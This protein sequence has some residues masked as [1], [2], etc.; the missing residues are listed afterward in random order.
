M[1]EK[2]KVIRRQKKWKTKSGYAY[3]RKAK[4]TRDKRPKGKKSIKDKK[5]TTLKL[6]YTRDEYG[7][8]V[9]KKSRIV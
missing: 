8:L 3:A 9:P 6:R 2:V 7:R 1:A 4:W 5:P